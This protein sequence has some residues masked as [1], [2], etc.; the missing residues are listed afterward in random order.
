METELRNS[1]LIMSNEQHKNC[2][3]RIWKTE[4][5]MEEL[6]LAEAFWITVE[7]CNK[8]LLFCFLITKLKIL[9]GLHKNLRQFVNTNLRK[10]GKL[11]KMPQ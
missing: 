2:D 10:D 6:M 1:N 8:D 7:S 5:I 11:I 4:T 9:E 3:T